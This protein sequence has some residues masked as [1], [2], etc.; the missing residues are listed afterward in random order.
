MNINIYLEET[1]AKSLNQCVKQ[2]G[3]SRNAIIREAINEWIL[4][5]QVK[6]WPTSILNFKGVAKTPSFESFR[7]ELTP[8]SD[9]NPLL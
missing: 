7:D 9:E 6:H 1:L 2:T 4:H 8:P 3:A 5:H